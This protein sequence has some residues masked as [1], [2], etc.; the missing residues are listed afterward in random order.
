MKPFYPQPETQI[1]RLILLFRFIC[2]KKP[3]TSKDEAE[4]R[5]LNNNIIENP[6][7]RDK[8]T[9]KP[10]IKP[11]TWK[12]NLRFAAGKVNA[13]N[14]KKKRIIK[15]LFGSESE[16]KENHLKGRLYF[17]PTFFKKCEKDVI[18]PLKRSTR[19]PANGPISFEVMKP[20]D[21]ADFHLLYLPY[22]KGDDFKEEKVAEDLN[23]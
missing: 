8:F 5:I 15:R 17:F 11:T 6:I 2:P 23:F 7:A 18:T 22:P 3:Y 14:E 4:F 16:E 13:E 20:G 21:S 9:G 1:C 10:Y 19:T 12:G